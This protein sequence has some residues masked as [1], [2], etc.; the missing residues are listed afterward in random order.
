MIIIPFKFHSNSQI[1]LKQPY[2]THHKNK[3]Q[4]HIYSNLQIILKHNINI[5]INYEY[6]T[7]KFTNNNFIINYD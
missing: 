5:N 2:K 7:F 1:I 4:L 6:I 3:S